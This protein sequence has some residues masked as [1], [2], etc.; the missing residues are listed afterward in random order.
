MQA[1]FVGKAVGGLAEAFDVGAVEGV[2]S[3]PIL[4]R[5]HVGREQ[6]LFGTT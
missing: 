5:Q 3:A 2:I 4:G 1:R 6:E